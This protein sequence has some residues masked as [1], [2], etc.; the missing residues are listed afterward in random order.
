MSASAPT[1]PTL[2]STGLL[3]RVQAVVLP[4]GTR[5]WTVL[6]ADYLPVQAVE[7][8]LEHHR[9]IGSSPNTV[10]S[11]ARGLALWWRHLAAS[12]AD[13]R[14]PPVAIATSFVAWLRAG[15]PCESVAYLPNAATARAGY[16]ESTI[17]SRLAAVGAF[18]R[19]HDMA[20]ALS[21][22]ASDAGRRARYR[23]FM[24]HVASRRRRRAPLVRLRRARPPILSPQQIDLILEACARPGPEPGEWRGSLRDRLLFELLSET[25]LRLGEA[26]GLQHRD[27][28][29]GRGETPF[30]EVVERAH[31]HGVRAKSGYRRVF[32][33]DGLERLYGEWVWQVSEIAADAGHEL[34]DDGYVFVNVAR[35]PY[36]SPTRPETVY[37]RVRW[38]KRRLG[39][40]LP[41]AW[42][43]HWLRHTHA[44]ALLLNG[45]A[46][47]VVMRRLGHADIQTTLSLYGWVTEEAELRGLADW[48]RF[49]DGWRVADEDSR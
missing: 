6:G 37:D 18:Y 31:P 46:P 15:A 12:G 34:A 39:A 47:H 40:A 19:Y 48:R 30:V 11:Y 43:P 2:P 42:T 8:F 45:T 13:W 9:Q 25:G 33:S 49:A 20:A 7:E 17:A 28:S 41:S 4:D 35:R 24:E 23:P 21:V 29:V 44:T 1:S 22:A 26:L 14:R 27:V 36:F 16:A 3:G 38:L 32:V 5:T 10:K